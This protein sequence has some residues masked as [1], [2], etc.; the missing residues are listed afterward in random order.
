MEVIVNSLV[1][2]ARKHFVMTYLI[3]A[4]ISDGNKQL[5]KSNSIVSVF[6]VFVCKIMEFRFSKTV[7]HI[8]LFHEGLNCV[9]METFSKRDD[10]I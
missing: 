4:Q 9:A 1:M 7:N 6:L 3:G 2:S 5:K 10:A 8:L